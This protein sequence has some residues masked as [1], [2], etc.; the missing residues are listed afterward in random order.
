VP[1][2]EVLGEAWSLYKRF[3]WQFFL[4]ALVVFAVLDLLSALADAAASDSVASGLFWGLVAVVVGIVGYFW[5]QTALVELVHDVRDGRADRSIGETYAAVR[6]RVPAAVVAGILAGIGIV[7]GFVLLIVPGLYLL[8]I[9]SMLI[10]VIV[11]ERR[12][13]GEAFTRSREVVRGHGWSVLGLVILTFLIVGIA[14]ALIRALFLPLPDFLD[15][16]L[17]SLVAHSLT[18]PFAVAALTTAYFRLAALE[19]AAAPALP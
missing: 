1:I 14:S 17:G 8:T 3:L 15:T 5:V 4:T 16:W 7:I 6:D 11:I 19:R 13:A 2:G 12:S 9:W 18:I 10:P